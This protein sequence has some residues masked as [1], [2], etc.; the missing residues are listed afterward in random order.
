VVTEPGTVRPVVRTPVV[1][2]EETPGTCGRPGNPDNRA[3]LAGRPKTK[4]GIPNSDW[5]RNA[6]L[7]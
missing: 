3:I 6:F 7:P 2:P 5:G 4:P 1:T